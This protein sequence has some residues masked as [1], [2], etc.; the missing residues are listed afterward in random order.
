[1]NKIL[2]IEDDTNLGMLLKENLDNK[3]FDTNW[4]K[5]SNAGLDEFRKSHYSLCLLDVML[6]VKDGFTLSKELKRI[7]PE[8]P[9]IFLT[10]R[11]MQNDKIKGF[12]HGCD[13]YI[14]KPFNTQE[15]YMRINAVLK[16]TQSSFKTHPNILQIGK[17][18]LN[19]T[20]RTLQHG[21]ETIKLSSK[22]TELLHILAGHINQLVNRNTI[23]E[24]VWG[25]DDYFSAKSMD[26]Y[27][28]KI[29][30]MLKGDATIE[31]LNAYGVGF[32]LVVNK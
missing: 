18:T 29:R 19:H 32:K 25:N 2:F 14:T 11:G 4:C 28:S 1:M 6:P 22:E 30:K 13:D 27:I 31:L 7:K 12:E 3:G 17:Y 21:N 15:L 5:D 20:N 26:V 23:L 9:I 10:A 24:K 16:R 8:V